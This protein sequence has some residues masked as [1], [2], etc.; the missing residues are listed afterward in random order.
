MKAS[1]AQRI[2]C[3]VKCDRSIQLAQLLR[4]L[5]WRR[6]RRQRLRCRRPSEKSAKRCNRTVPK[7]PN[8]IQKAES[9]LK[10]RTPVADRT[11]AKEP[12]LWKRGGEGRPLPARGAPLNKLTTI[13]LSRKKKS[14]SSGRKCVESMLCKVHPELYLPPLTQPIKNAPNLYHFKRLGMLCWLDAE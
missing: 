7:M 1:L 13:K 5:Y 8:R 4:E 2:D 14:E 6:R 11:P 10:S 12:N 3:Q 9:I